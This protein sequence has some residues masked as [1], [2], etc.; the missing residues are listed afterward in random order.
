[1]A[2]RTFGQSAVTCGIGGTFAVVAEMAALLTETVRSGRMTRRQ[3]RSFGMPA[4][5]LDPAAA[6]AARSAAV[7]TPAPEQRMDHISIVALGSGS[8]VILIPGL[9]SPRAVWDGVASDLARTHRVIL[10]Q[11]NGFGG[12]DPGAN[13]KPGILDGIVAD[14]HAYQAKNALTGAAMVGHSMGGLVGMML[15]RAHPGDV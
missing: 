1:M 11:V 8:P 14:L 5:T 12:D 10:V 4:T 3:R 9:A 7:A 2:A 15:A 13:L 6:P